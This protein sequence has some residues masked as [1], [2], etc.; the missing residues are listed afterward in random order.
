MI[1]PSNAKTA[2]QDFKEMKDLGNMHT[3]EHD[4]FPITEL[5]EVEICDLP[6]KEF[7][8]VVLRKLSELRKHSKQFNQIRKRVH[9]KARS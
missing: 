5:K 6:D 7:K 3:E 8:V 2:T 9:K 1:S 4:N